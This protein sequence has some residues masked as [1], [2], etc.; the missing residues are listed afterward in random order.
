MNS[1]VKSK[2]ADA[3][4][5]PP[6]ID[7]KKWRKNFQTETVYINLKKYAIKTTSNTKE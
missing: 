5:V 6:R 1:R 4:N 3:D 7:K 2:A